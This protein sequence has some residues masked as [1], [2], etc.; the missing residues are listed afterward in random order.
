MI[1]KKYDNLSDNLK[2]NEVK[3]YYNILKRKKISLLLKRLF[4]IVVSFLLLIILSPIFLVLAICIKIDSK[5]SVFFRQERVTR[6]GKIF[7]IFKFRTMVQD[8]DKKGSL[9]T[10]KQ[11]SR[12]TR[13]GKTI[14]KVRLDELPQL[15]NV[16]K[17]DMSFVG[18]RPEVKKYVEQYTNE[19]KATLLMPAGITSTA[20]IKYKDEDEIIEKGINKGKTV[21]ETYIEEVLPEKMRYNLEY[22]KKFSVWEDLKICV[23][24]V[25]GVMK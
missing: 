15:I 5:G 22:I 1:L 9:V 4:D 12:I 2:N 21:D 14:R 8:A 18:T 10:Q 20:S 25:I 17:G 6:Y 19:M 16:L 11:D 3:K 13:V 7:R 24:T 23:K